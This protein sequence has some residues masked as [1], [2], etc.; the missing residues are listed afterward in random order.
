MFHR[1]AII[2]KPIKHGKLKRNIVNVEFPNHER[3][4]I[5]DIIHP[6]TTE[7]RRPINPEIKFEIKYI[8]IEI[9][10]KRNEYLKQ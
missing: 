9:I 2:I 1:Y 8:I 3:G 5:I 10:R 6:I 4:R 7:N